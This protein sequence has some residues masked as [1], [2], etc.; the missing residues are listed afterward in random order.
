MRKR[1]DLFEAYI[2]HVQSISEM[3]VFLKQFSEKH[4]FDT[5][6]EITDGLSTYNS[7]PYDK[8]F[9]FPFTS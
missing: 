9:I 5:Y 6:E 8:A 7:I 3:D 4:I 2:K 1:T